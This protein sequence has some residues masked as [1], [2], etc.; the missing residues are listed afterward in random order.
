MKPWR[1]YG[2]NG[3]PW[4]LGYR[5]SRIIHGL[6]RWTRGRGTGATYNWDGIINKD[7]IAYIGADS[8]P[9]T[10]CY[11]NPDPRCCTR[12]HRHSR[13]NADTRACAKTDPCVCPNRDPNTGTHTHTG[14][15]FSAGIGSNAR[16][17]T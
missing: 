8:V 7:E 11:R 17:R 10:G 5:S 16:C 9:C 1:L 6:L 14:S 15:Y 13:A 4:R 3:V 12:A 2:A